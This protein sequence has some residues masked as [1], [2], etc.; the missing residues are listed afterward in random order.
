MADFEVIKTQEELDNIIKQRLERERIKIEN[1]FKSQIQALEDEKKSIIQEKD[2]ALSSVADLKA[3]AGEVEAL[4]NKIGEY[5][6]RELRRKVAYEK[7]IPFNLADRIQG[8]D[9]D[10]MKA[11]ADTLSEY[12]K[13]QTTA[14]MKNLEPVVK[15]ELSS[16]YSKL[17]EGI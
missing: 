11:D 8:D 13:S 16:A 14:P 10:S 17:I 9:E 1:D 6:K 3:K 12:F 5:E 15:D 4:E 2:K 7:G